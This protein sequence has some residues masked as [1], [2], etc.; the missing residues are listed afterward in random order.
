MR[1][2]KNPLEIYP[3]AGPPPR[4]LIMKVTI[5]PVKVNRSSVA[6][7]NYLSKIRL[8]TN[9]YFNAYID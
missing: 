5:H 8:T 2:P 7:T 1:P 9:G 3:D 6:L 4:S